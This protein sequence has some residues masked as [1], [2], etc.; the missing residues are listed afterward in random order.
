MNKT[1]KKLRKGFVPDDSSTFDA[2][3]VRLYKKKKKKKTTS[4][5]QLIMFGY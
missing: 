1:Y 2:R 3:K 5:D 4:T